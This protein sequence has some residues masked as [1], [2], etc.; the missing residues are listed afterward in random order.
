MHVYVHTCV[1]LHTH[2][3]TPRET[4]RKMPFELT[5]LFFGEVRTQV[6]LSLCPWYASSYNRNKNREVIF[7]LEGRSWA[8]VF[9]S[10][11]RTEKGGFLEIPK[12]TDHQ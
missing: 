11:K 7:T 12:Y 10:G 8:E 2:A 1:C 9:P 6:F 5:I 3:C 4:S